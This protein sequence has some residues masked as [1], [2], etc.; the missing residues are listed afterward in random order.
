MS[1]LYPET[2]GGGI[3]A[4]D[5]DAISDEID[6]GGL[7]IGTRVFNVDVG[8]NFV[9][10][11]SDASLVTDE[12]LA[13]KGTD[14]SRWIVSA[15]DFELN[16][17]ASLSGDGTPGDPLAVVSAPAPTDATVFTATLNLATTSLKGMQ[18]SNSRS[19]LGR[20]GANIANSDATIAP[21]TGKFTSARLLPNTLSAH[22]TL[23]LSSAD[24][25]T[26]DL[27]Y[28]IAE[29]LGNFNLIVN[30]NA[31]NQIYLWNGTTAGRGRRIAFYRASDWTFNTITW[32]ES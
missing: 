2:P 20:F 27:F 25:A 14:G 31:G 16:T 9:L 26:G 23:T 29:D 11:V 6:V 4:S 5:S 8:S 21:G 19:E 13:V 15:S 24:T 1:V 28:L 30:D 18:S 3:A 7:P 32:L 22:R 12:I 17:N 10:T